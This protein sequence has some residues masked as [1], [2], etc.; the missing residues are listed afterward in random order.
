MSLAR[1]TVT[2]VDSPRVEPK[3]GEAQL[4][5]EEARQRR[6]RR[7]FIGLV[8]F[9][10]V[11]L[12]VA[13]L[14][15]LASGSP[16]HSAPP[17]VGLPR[18][19]PPQGK[20]Q[21]APALFVAGDGK[22]GIG[23]Y[24]T[25]NGVLIRTISPQGPGGPDEQVELSRNRQSVFFV[26][27]TGPCSG[28]ILNGPVSGSSAPAV[29]I[30]DPQTLALSPSPNP[31]SRDLAWVG[32]TC[33]PT[34]ST[35]S[36]TLYITNLATGLRSDLGAFSGQHSDDA[37]SWNSDGTRL[38]VESGTTVAMFDTN[39]SSPRNVGLLDV[40]SG[41]TLTS[42][43]F[44]SQRSQLAVIQTCYGTARTAGTSQVLVFNVVTGKPVAIV[45]SAPQGTTFQ[46]LSVDASGQ[47]ILLGV[48]TDFP[49]GAHNMQLESGHLVAVGGNAPTDAQW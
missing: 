8:L 22:G 17:H 45:A 29:V 19:T 12:A 7:W 31:T 16:R 28:N 13:L 18:W 36:S 6:R 37:I 9:V 34:G 4:L 35:T 30:S 21:A 23:V 14:V 10:V 41:C 38:A 47:H 20:T 1:P 48:V 40:T 46:G 42:P 11:S 27:P 3:L 44:L 26:Q 39:R 33:G 32:V 24:S 2:V 15:S 49:L 43:T 5:F 25:A